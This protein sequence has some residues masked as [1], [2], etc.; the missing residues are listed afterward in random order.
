MPGLKA[1]LEAIDNRSDFKTFMQNYAFA[2]GGVNNKGPRRDG[3]REEGFV[4]VP[5]TMLPWIVLTAM[6]P[7]FHRSPRSLRTHPRRA[8][9]PRRSRRIAAGRRS[10]L[11]W[12]S[13]WHATTSTSRPSW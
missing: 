6:R 9:L 11:T 8:T 1:A 2:H 5:C 7:S 12:R 4:C 10:A 13:R 3:P